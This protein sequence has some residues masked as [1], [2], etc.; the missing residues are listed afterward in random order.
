M[1]YFTTTQFFEDG[2][3]ITMIHEDDASH[4]APFFTVSIE[5]TVF[6]MNWREA[7]D[8]ARLLLSLIDRD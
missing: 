3:E 4:P 2:H 7:R 6:R 5:D 8:F 1:R